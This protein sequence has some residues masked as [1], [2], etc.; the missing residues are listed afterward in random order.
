MT[1]GFDFL[2]FMYQQDYLFYIK[3]F[4]LSTFI[5]VSEPN[6]LPCF[7][8][9]KRQPRSSRK[10]HSSSLNVA[11]VVETLVCVGYALS[12]DPAPVGQVP[13]QLLEQDLRMAPYLSLLCRR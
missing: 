4:V 2:S 9:T 10:R 13:R 3:S 1:D 5:Y 12:P 11:N 8:Y 6:L 7:Y